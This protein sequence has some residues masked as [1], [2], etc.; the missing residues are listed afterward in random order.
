MIPAEQTH[1]AV[2]VR[3][4]C[5]N[6]GTAFH[7]GTAYALRADFRTTFWC[8]SCNQDR[9][10]RQEGPVLRLIVGGAVRTR[11]ELP[12]AVQGRLW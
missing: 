5:E 8:H 1:R 7:D 4:R 2:P 9:K 10:R 12:V 6:C 3:L 11:I